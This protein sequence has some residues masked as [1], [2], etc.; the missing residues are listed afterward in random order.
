MRERR[1]GGSAP[2]G[3]ESRGCEGVEADAP[4]GAETGVA[5]AG[6][7]GGPAEREASA[8][9]GSGP[10]GVMAGWI[11]SPGADVMGKKEIEG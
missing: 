5:A 1:T 10:R 11:A 9:I 8:G 4:G 7:P 2:A 3:T 6:K